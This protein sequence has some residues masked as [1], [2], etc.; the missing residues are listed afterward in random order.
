MFTDTALIMFTLCSKHAA[1]FTAC[2]ARFAWDFSACSVCWNSYSN[3][4]ACP[5]LALAWFEQ[6]GGSFCGE[7]E[8]GE[9]SG[10]VDLCGLSAEC[11]CIFLGKLNSLLPFSADNS[12][13][14]SESDC[15]FQVAFSAALPWLS[16]IIP[17]ESPFENL[18]AH[19]RTLAGTVNLFIA[20]ALADS[21]VSIGMQWPVFARF[22][23]KLPMS[24]GDVQPCCSVKNYKYFNM[25]L[26]HNPVREFKPLWYA[27]E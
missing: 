3:F 27:F 7:L 4:L 9:S 14:K 19:K 23:F 16:C 24:E 10:Y 21:P 26:C 1:L 20:L 18:L 5:T 22:P 2:S 17:T 6:S 15:P 8:L 11:L 25:V 12:C 13:T